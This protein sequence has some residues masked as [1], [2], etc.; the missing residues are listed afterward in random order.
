MNAPTNELLKEMSRL[1]MLSGRVSDVQ[2]KNLQ[3]YPLVYFEGVAEVKI[4]YDLMPQKSISDEEPTKCNSL[5]SYYL[6]L[7]ESKNTDL[8][9][10]YLALE[11]SVQ[12]L[13]WNDV[14]IEVY[15]NNKIVY[16][17]SKI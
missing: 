7:D 9:K 12:T 4:D 17:S 6:M 1:T 10:R 3:Y 11:K 15:F 5:I 14:K 16:K 2:L 13:F 8:D